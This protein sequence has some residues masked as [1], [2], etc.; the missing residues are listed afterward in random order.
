MMGARGAAA[1]PASTATAPNPAKPARTAS[2]KTPEAAPA[3]AATPQWTSN[4]AAWVGRERNSAAFELASINKVNVWMRQA[5]P[6]LVVRC[7][8]QKAEAFVFTSSAARM[9]PEDENHTVRIQFDGGAAATERWADSA[10]HDALFAPDGAAFVQ[11]LVSARQ[12]KFG[13]SPHNAD[14]AVAT[15][16]VDGLAGHL[17]SAAR[18]CGWKNR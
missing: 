13:F 10:E 18:Q 12:L 6:V 15:F 14:P 4:A 8:A 11:R 9:E 17:A 5:Q 16:E 7:R 3:R 2:A 1:P